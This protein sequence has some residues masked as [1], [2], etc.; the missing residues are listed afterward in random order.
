MSVVIGGAVSA[1]WCPRGSECA[2]MSGDSACVKLRGAVQ[3]E[4]S[5]IVGAQNKLSLEFSIGA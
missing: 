2:R 3:P 4:V 5:V 1:W